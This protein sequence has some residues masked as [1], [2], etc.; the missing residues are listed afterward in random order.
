VTK[1]HKHIFALGIT[2][3]FKNE[4][5]EGIFCILKGHFQFRFN[6]PPA[7]CIA[8]LIQSLK[9]THD[10]L[11]LGNNRLDLP[12]VSFFEFLNFAHSAHAQSGLS[13]N[14]LLLKWGRDN[15]FYNHV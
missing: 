6:H 10:T 1:Q 5:L 14:S 9:L 15:F 7:C 13:N 11:G 8:R 12:R 4:Y 3:V 2:D